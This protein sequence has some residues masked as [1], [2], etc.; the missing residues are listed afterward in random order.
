M[1]K[2]KLIDNSEYEKLGRE[3]ATVLEIGAPNRKR[4]MINAFWRG[5]ASG[6]GAVI[7]GTIVVALIAWLLG[8]LQHIP[9][10]GAA[11]ETIVDTVNSR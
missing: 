3:I 4:M 5:V 8:L 2:P 7:G 11:V 10:L 1:K 9:L 6:F